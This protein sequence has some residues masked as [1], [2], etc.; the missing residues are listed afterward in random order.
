MSPPAAP[1]GGA[2]GTALRGEPVDFTDPLESE[3]AY[4]IALAWREL[5]RGASAAALRDHFFGTGDDALD[6]GQMDTLDLL[7]QRP[8]WRMSELAEALRVDP[9]TATRAVQ[10]LVIDGLAE[11]RPSGADGRVVMVVASAEGRRRHE[12]VALRRVTAMGRLLAVFDAD[13]RAR[14]ADLMM[15][16]VHSLDDLVDEL[17]VEQSADDDAAAS[18]AGA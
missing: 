6:P 12:D 9:S 3:H 15:R 16:F 17:V 8:E 7:I 4:R 5:R 13:E 2:T 1:T 11:R 14:L 10:R 18:T